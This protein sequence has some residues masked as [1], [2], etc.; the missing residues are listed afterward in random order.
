[1]SVVVYFQNDDDWF[2]A[3]WVFSRLCEDIKARYHLSEEEDYKLKQAQAL[4]G[5]ILQYIQPDTRA[6]I[7]KM[8]KHT[9]ADIINDKSSMYTNGL[10]DEGYQLYRSSLP[11]LVELIEKYENADWPPV[12]E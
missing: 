8:I 3:N 5:L 1:M 2:K 7:M 12:K 4:G 11:S 9:A 6:S 10:D